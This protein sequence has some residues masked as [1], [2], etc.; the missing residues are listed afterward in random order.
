L[1]GYARA[2]LRN[3]I[4]YTV[5]EEQHLQALAGLRVLFMPRSLVI[6]GETAEALSRFVQRGGT[7]VCESECGAFGSNGLYRY[8]E[9]RFLESLAGIREVGRRSLTSHELV[10]TIGGR[11]VRLPA[12]QWLTPLAGKDLEVWAES[13][14]G[15]ILACRAVGDGRVLVCGTYCGEAYFAGSRW[16]DEKYSASCGGFEHYVRTVAG[17][18]GALPSVR[19]TRGR[20]VDVRCGTSE[21]ARVVFV[22]GKEGDPVALEFPAGHWTSPPKDILSGASVEL[23][24]EGETIRCS[25]PP[26][27]WGVWVLRED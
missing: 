26:S 22:M 6:D 20:F 16:G 18:A 23:S 14:D 15:P 9:E 19:S 1:L 3:H 25:L 2:L 17:Q 12:R 21:G 4:P 13:E 11:E 24:S 5:V 7:L 8:P 27:E 10:A